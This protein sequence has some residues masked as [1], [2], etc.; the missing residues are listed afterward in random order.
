MLR[1]DVDRSEAVGSIGMGVE[2][3]AGIF[4]VTF[5]ERLEPRALSRSEGT[6]PSWRVPALIKQPCGWNRATGE[7]S[8]RHQRGGAPYEDCGFA[9]FLRLETAGSV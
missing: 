3:S 2:I 7:T 9:G 1:T 8:K 4:R 5:E 6:V